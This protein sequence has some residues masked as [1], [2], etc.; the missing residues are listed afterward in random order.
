VSD[1]NGAAWKWEVADSKIRRIWV[2]TH[3]L[4][5]VEVILDQ[6]GEAYKI[7]MENRV[8]SPLQALE[9]SDISQTYSGL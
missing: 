4:E 6:F 3:P 9:C 1:R 2:F 5:M 7:V 8:E